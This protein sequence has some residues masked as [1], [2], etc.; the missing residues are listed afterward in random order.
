MTP[1]PL[2]SVWLAGA[3]VATAMVWVFPY[4]AALNNPNERTRVLQ[5]RALVEQGRLAIGEARLDPA[6]RLLTTDL[7]GAEHRGLFV[8]DVA[9][10]CRDR[11]RRPP[12]DGPILPAKSPGVALLGA[13]PLAAAAA[14]GFV[15]PGPEG[16]LRAHAV[17]RWVAVI[18][19]IW[20]AWAA[21]AAMLA[22][23]GVPQP[24]IARCLLVAALGTGLFPYGII[25]VGHALAGAALVGGIAALDVARRRRRAVSLAVLAGAVSGAAVWFEYHAVLG[26]A[27]IAAWVAV[28]RDRLRIGPGFAVGLA[29]AA[30]PLAGVQHRLFGAPWRTGHAWLAGAGNRWSQ[31]TG[32]LGIDGLHA[33]AL[34]DALLDPYM[35]LV[36]FMPWLA[37]AGVAGAVAVVVDR[38]GDRGPALVCLAIAA[39]YLLFVSSLG[40]WRA[41]NGWSIGPRYLVPAMFP[42]AFVA[43]IG[44]QRVARHSWVGDAL[45]AGLGA[46]SVLVVSLTTA[47]HPSPPASV[48]NTFAE[49]TIPMLRDGHGVRNLGTLFG[50]GSAGLA[51]FVGLA[52]LCAAGVLWPVREARGP[53]ALR[54][55]VA[56]LA[57]ALWIGALA[58]APTRDAAEREET[59]RFLHDTVE[60]VSPQSEK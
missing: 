60:G 47:A 10:V 9:V 44:W 22:R 49:V 7:Y 11:Q 59:L 42:L 31:E 30:A 41:M 38:R 56:G 50:V 19:P 3:L 14:I 58:L 1:D 4:S 5:A 12:C 55:G 28:S 6:G 35:G 29:A 16:E 46:A 17:V 52:G 27:C 57:A 40:R 13:I 37:A 25:A 21:W 32:L 54:V 45:L 53:I 23:A 8:G 48:V 34:A 33:G 36:P 2:R 51:G 26:I 18:V 20:I 39:V 15:A 43:A 24:R